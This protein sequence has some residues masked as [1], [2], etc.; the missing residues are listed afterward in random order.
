MKVL[1]IIDS[2]G[3]YG[4]EIMLLNLAAEQVKLGL[5]PVIAS[6]GEKGIDSKPLE[7]E[8]EKRGLVAKK[9]RMRPGPNLGGAVKVLRYARKGH[10]D[11]LHSHGYK[12][13]IL[14]GFIPR[15]LRQIPLI[16]TLHGWTSTGGHFRSGHVRMRI[17]EWVDA[18][19]LKFMDAVV[20]VNRGM[21]SHPWL[22]NISH[23]K[24]NV[25]NNGI[26]LT[27]ASGSSALPS[28]KVISQDFIDLDKRIVEFCQGGFTLG[29]I[30]RFSSEK[31]FIYLIEAVSISRE[32]FG[33]IRLVIIGEGEERKALRKKIA[34]CG[35]E[36]QVLL[37][38]YKREARQYLKLFDVFVMSSLVEGLPMSLLEAMEARVPIIAT[39]VGGIPEVLDDGEAGLLVKP[40]DSQGMSKAI[41]CLRNDP[42]SG[43]GRVSY[44]AK[45]VAKR[46][47][48]QAMAERYREVYRS[49]LERW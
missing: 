37:P 7:V 42:Q 22:K 39:Q 12:G 35:L 44:A 47:S 18:H 45:I 16:S 4:A 20:L 30:G 8:A 43:L 40:A 23:A 17:Y 5:V 27:S 14:F 36:K 48:S 38:G 6:I 46:Y 26:S 24:L 29:S 10:F 28:E 9:F 33:D 31:G 19:S 1:H 3:L 21:L 15:G 32:T 49:A 2:G 25:V 13:N 11:I 41:G 34:E